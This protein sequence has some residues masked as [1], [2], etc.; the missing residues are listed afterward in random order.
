M[1]ALRGLTEEM[2]RLLHELAKAGNLA[3]L[4]AM[5]DA[6]TVVTSAASAE[7]VASRWPDAVVI[8]S[9]DELHVLLS[10]GYDSCREYRD[11]VVG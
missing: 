6:G 8:E 10:E 7:Q 4:P 9:P 3:I 1:V 2:S 11:R 5:E